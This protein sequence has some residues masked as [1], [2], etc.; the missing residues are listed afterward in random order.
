MDRELERWLPTLAPPPG[1]EQRLRVAIEQR[2]REAVPAWRPALAAVCCVLLAAAALP[3]PAARAPRPDVAR[4]LDLPP[5]PAVRVA[6]G[7][8]L[9]V[10]V[11]TEGV[12]VVLV[13]DLGEGPTVR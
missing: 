5:P 1:G 7:A 6:H 4:A 3:T 9:E 11:A 12:R 13:M 2:R 8:A 10:P